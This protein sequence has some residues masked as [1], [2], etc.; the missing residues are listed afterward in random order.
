M[1]KG[2]RAAKEDFVHGQG[3]LVEYWRESCPIPLD[4]TAPQT[5]ASA[6]PKANLESLAVKALFNISAAISTIVVKLPDT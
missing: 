1:R 3:Q 2:K 6:I 4:I 5:K